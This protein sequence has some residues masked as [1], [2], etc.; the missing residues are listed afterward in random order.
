MHY[1]RI[2]VLRSGLTV[3]THRSLLQRA[4]TTVICWG[5]YL[6]ICWTSHLKRHWMSK[7]S[8]NEQPRA[9]ACEQSGAHTAATQP[10]SSRKHF[11]GHTHSPQRRHAGRVG[12][13]INCERPAQTGFITRNVHTNSTHQTPWWE[14]NS[15]LADEEIS[16][17]WHKPK[18]TELVTLLSQ[19]NPINTFPSRYVEINPPSTSRFSKWYI[20]FI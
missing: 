16:C 10:A 11:E 6:I 2:A 20:P 17:F 5:S 4:N 9:A 15:C 13:G 12:Q 7:T 18:S 14:P 3:C 8:H 1:N 19:M